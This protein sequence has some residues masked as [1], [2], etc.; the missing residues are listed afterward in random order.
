MFGFPK[1]YKIG[2]I[3]LPFS[4]FPFHIRAKV[5]CSRTEYG[6]FL[7]EREMEKKEEERRYGREEQVGN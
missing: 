4:L 7:A 3:V 1:V 6:A 2:R 5:E